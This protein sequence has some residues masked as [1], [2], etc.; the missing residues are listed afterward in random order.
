MHF[1]R[2]TGEFS[3]SVT[4]YNPD[5]FSLSGNSF[6]PN[7]RFVYTSS[8][9]DL[10]QYDTWDSNMVADV[11]HVAAWDSFADPIYNVS[12][13]FFMHQLAPDGRI[14]LSAWNGSKY[15]NVISSPDSDGL[16]CNFHPHSYVIPQ[17]SDN[18]PSFPNYDLGALEGSA[19]DT[20]Y[21]HTPSATKSNFDIRLSPNPAS[22]FFNIVYS[23]NH[24]V[25]LSIT[26]LFGKEV[27]HLTLYPYFKNRIIYTSDLRNGI[28]LLTMREDGQEVSKKLVVQR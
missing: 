13:L 7:S 4:V 28:Y 18:I 23:V 10:Y 25:Q 20:L 1:D 14:Y 12:V 6:S 24:D 19:C 9:Y 16:A 8:L 26:D 5:S 17:Y 15:Y 27:K 3:N 21:L 2:C 22:Q 11:V